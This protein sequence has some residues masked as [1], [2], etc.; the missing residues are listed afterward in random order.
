M[1]TGKLTL[2]LACSLAAAVAIPSA[3]A[4]GTSEEKQ[5]LL[6]NTAGDCNVGATDGTPM[7]KSFVIMRESDGKVGAKIRLRGAPHDGEWGIEFDQRPL[8]GC[9]G[10]DGFITTN[11]KGNGTAHVSEPVLPGNTGAFVR[12]IPLNTNAD[13]FGVIANE[14]ADLS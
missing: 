4:R 13:P 8:E 9:D 7:E 11:S 6:A 1:L 10:F 12:L 5:Q 14:G 2:A 3:L